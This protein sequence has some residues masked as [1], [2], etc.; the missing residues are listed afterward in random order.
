MTSNDLEMTFNS[1]FS[2]Y[3]IFGPRYCPLIIQKWKLLP[4]IIIDIILLYIFSRKSVQK[5][6][7]L[8]L[9]MKYDMKIYICFSCAITSTPTNTTPTLS[10]WAQGEDIMKK[11]SPQYLLSSQSY[12]LFSKSA[13]TFDLKNPRWPP[14]AA[15]L[16][17]E[18]WTYLC[19]GS[20]YRDGLFFK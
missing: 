9:F 17:F 15:I 7:L 12:V 10:G 1:V 14:S 13:M 16:D 19:N 4:L 8:K 20:R 6:Q 5:K 11:S 18:N 3:M 2:T